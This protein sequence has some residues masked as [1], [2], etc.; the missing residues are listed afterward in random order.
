MKKNTILYI[1]LVFLIAVNGFFLFNHIGYEPTNDPKKSQQNKEFIVEELGFN[2]SQTKEFKEKSKGHHKTMMRLTDD[3][4]KLKD[5][6]FGTLSDE[7]INEATID[8]ISNLICEIEKEKEKEIFY[9]FKMIRDIANAEQR[10]K[11]NTI[12]LDALRQGDRGNRPPPQDGAEGHRPP[13]PR[14]N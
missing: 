14:H 7:T 1:L 2:A 10:E 6:L 3:V 4:R 11:F 12:L 13:P 8:S 5:E 9:H